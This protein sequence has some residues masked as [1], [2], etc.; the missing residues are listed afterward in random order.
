MC[1]PNNNIIRQLLPY[2][3]DADDFVEMDDFCGICGQF[4]CNCVE[5]EENWW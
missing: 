5:V 4:A 1:Q 3:V 2:G